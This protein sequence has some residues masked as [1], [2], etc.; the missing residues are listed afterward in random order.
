MRPGVRRV[1]AQL[2][3]R[4]RYLAARNARLEE[5]APD[6]PLGSSDAGRGT[7]APDRGAGVRAHLDS[8]RGR[9]PAIDAGERR[10]WS[11][12]LP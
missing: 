8:I 4:E 12:L 1:E 7:P 2:R 11:D 6:R 10:H 5:E 9:G 3:A